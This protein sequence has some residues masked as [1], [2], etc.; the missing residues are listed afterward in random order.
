[1]RNNTKVPDDLLAVE[2]DMTESN[3]QISCDPKL[4]SL[5]A[6]GMGQ[7]RTCTPIGR[8]ARTFVIETE[9]ATVVAKRMDY[10]RAPGVYTEL[11]DRLNERSTLPCPRLLLTVPFSDCWYAVFTHVDGVVPNPA[12]PTWSG[13]WREAF[14]LMQRLRE[15]KE[16]VPPWD[17]KAMWLDRLLQVDLPDPF[18][19]NLLHRLLE[20]PI[21]DQVHLAHGDF[22]AQNLLCTKDGLMLVDWEEVGVAPVGF[23]AGWVLA[24]NRIGSG[25]QQ[26]PQEVFNDLA[27]RGFPESN[28]R[29]YEGLGLLRLLYRAMTLSMSEVTR[30]FVM[31]RV[32]SAISD[33]E[34]GR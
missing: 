11:F 22:S 27:G 21:E 12:N 32:R 23:D 24:L 9:R 13:V 3:R 1:M 33:K 31:Q 2:R 26:S 14:T 30:A 28:L 8:S 34:E 4:L 20:T 5:I 17:L 6:E 19:R 10:V 29:W 16:I 25:P 7:V 15:E 18:A